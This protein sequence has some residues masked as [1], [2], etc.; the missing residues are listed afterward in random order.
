MAKYNISINEKMALGKGI[1]TF[2]QL[3][4][5]VV[6]FEKSKEKP[7]TKSEL[8]EGL[9]SAFADMRLMMVG[10]IKRID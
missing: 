7:A 2:L 8:Y 10:N 1:T 5:Q 3:V 6:T 4:P 9:D